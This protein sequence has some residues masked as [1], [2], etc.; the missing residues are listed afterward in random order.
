LIGS[1]E[2]SKNAQNPSFTLRAERM[3]KTNT[4]N[5]S[6]VGNELNQGTDKFTGL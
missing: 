5:N 1:L 4:Q 3:R 2:T 6:L